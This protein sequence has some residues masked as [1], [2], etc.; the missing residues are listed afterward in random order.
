MYKTAFFGLI[1][2]IVLALIGGAAYLFGQGKINISVSPTSSPQATI[3]GTPAPTVDDQAAIKQAVYTK[4]GSDATKLNVT[5]SKIE[6][7]YATG[8][9]VDVGSEVGGGYFLAAKWQG[10]WVIVH[11]GQAHPTCAQIAPYNFPVS[12]V[13]E[14]LDATGKVVKR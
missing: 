9:I 4:F 2:I 7:N 8:G 11:D 14:C 12:M 5:V 6:G 1:A 13:A 10:N 3:Q